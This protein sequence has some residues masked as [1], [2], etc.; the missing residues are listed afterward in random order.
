MDTY[1]PL[2]VFEDGKFKST[3]IIAKF[4]RSSMIAYYSLSDGLVCAGGR[5]L[6]PDPTARGG[7]GR[8]RRRWRS[9]DASSILLSPSSGSGLSQEPLRH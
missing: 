6:P 4:K 8:R 1:I 5:V 7:G 3:S 2:F 9:P